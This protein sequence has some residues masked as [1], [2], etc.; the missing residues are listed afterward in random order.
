MSST[1]CASVFW[2]A[3]TV[4]EATSVIAARLFA[5]FVVAIPLWTHD[6]FVRGSSTVTVGTNEQLYVVEATPDDRD[7]IKWY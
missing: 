6:P 4:V 3:N 5:G 2:S 7:I 1:S